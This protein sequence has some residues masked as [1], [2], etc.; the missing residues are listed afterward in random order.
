MS[1]IP[2]LLHLA[3]NALILGQRLSELCGHAPVLEEDLALANMA[4]DLIG[5][6]RLLLSHAG[7]LE[8]NGR[9]EDALVY[10][11]D[12]D[13]Y[14]NFTMLELPNGDFA[15]T[16]VRN[17]LFSAYQCELWRALSASKDTELAAIAA[18]A[19][20]EARYHARHSADWVVRLGDGTEESHQR[21]QQA[22][23]LL[24]PYTN[25]F[26]SDLAQGEE[27]II[28]GVAVAPQSLE[29]SWT[30]AVR[31]VLE[32]ATLQIPAASRFNSTGKYGVHSEHLG[33]LLGEMQVLHR[34]HPGAIW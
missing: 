31:P 26:F 25:E 18:K 29:P 22:L 20:K 10:W 12:A 9:D 5:Q 6:A 16:T 4:L 14:R 1:H 23:A 32:E 34:A 3:D 17:F 33:Y 19:L 7:K 24:W 27:A 21:T 30:S 8:G 13:Q 11:R 2:Y 28:Q 15:F